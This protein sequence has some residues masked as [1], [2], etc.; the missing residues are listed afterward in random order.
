MLI[1]FV[2]ES[3]RTLFK[4]LLKYGKGVSRGGAPGRFFGGAATEW[5]ERLASGPTRSLMLTKWL[6]NRSLDVDRRT[7]EDNEAWAVELNSGTQDAQ[8]GVASFRERRD[9]IWRGF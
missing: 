9:P 7:L 5:A 8:E 1:R 2:D 6:V 4:N 3:V